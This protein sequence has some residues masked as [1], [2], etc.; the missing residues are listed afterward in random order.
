MEAYVFD[1]YQINRTFISEIYNCTLGFAGRFATRPTKTHLFFQGNCSN[2][3]GYA[4]FSI[5]A[6]I[7]YSDGGKRDSILS[8]LVQTPFFLDDLVKAV[9]DKEIGRAHV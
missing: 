7:V 1:I 5:F 9:L 4:A 8:A 2:L 3:T 6:G